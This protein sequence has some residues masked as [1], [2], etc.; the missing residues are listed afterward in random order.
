MFVSVFSAFIAFS[1]HPFNNFRCLCLYIDL[2]A[3]CVLN[4]YLFNIFGCLC[5]TYGILAHINM[6]TYQ[7]N[8]KWWM[9]LSYKNFFIQP[10]LSWGDLYWVYPFNHFRCLCLSFLA[11]IAFSNY[12]FNIFLCVCST[13][14]ILGQIVFA[15]YQF[16]KSWWM[17]LFWRKKSSFIWF[18]LTW[19]ESVDMNLATYQFNK[20]WCIC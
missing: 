11:F 20:F 8:K 13:Y 14:S 2:L 3:V 1:N 18:E 19:L 9:F 12:P 7:F 10:D 4:S 5:I 16:N 6:A 15:A 17:C